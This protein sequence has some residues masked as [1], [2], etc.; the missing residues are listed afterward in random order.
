MLCSLLYSISFLSIP[1]HI[2]TASLL[3]FGRWFSP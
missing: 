3:L 1:S 2:A